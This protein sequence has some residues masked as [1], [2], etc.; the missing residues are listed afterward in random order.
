MRTWLR[1]LALTSC[2][3]PGA[4]A[5]VGVSTC[6]GDVCPCGNVD[7]LA[8]CG[9]F[10][11]DGDPLTGALLSGSGSADLF[12]DDLVL[13]AEGLAPDQFGLMAMAASGGVMIPLGD[14]NFCLSAAGGG[15]FRFPPRLSDSAGVLRETGILAAAAEF[16]AGVT[17]GSTWNFQAWYRDS[18]G[19]CGSGFNLS[20]ALA[21]TFEPPGSDRALEVELAGRPIAQF[22][23][24]ERT[25]ASNQGEDLWIN[26]D[27]G[28]LGHLSGQNVLVYVV[29]ARTSAEWDAN[30]TL[31]DVRGAAQPFLI[32]SG[33]IAAGSLLVDPGQLNGELGTQLGVGYDIVI[34][35]NMDGLL[36]PQDVID[37]RGDV[38]GVVVVRDPVQAGPFAVSSSMH[39]L[40]FFQQQVVFYPTNISSM[41]ALPLV[42]V[43]HGNGHNFQW[44]D[45]IGNHLASYGY[46]VMSHTNDTM[47]GI[48]TASLTTLENTDAFLGNLDIIANGELD[49]H[50][51]VDHMAWIGHSRGGEGIVR[52]Y[53]RV[54][55]GN[56][57]PQNFG[58]D[59][60]RLLSSIAPT[61]FLGANFSTPH[62]AN[63][64]LWVGSAD[65]D[66]T[67]SPGPGGGQS[68]PL[69]E[70]GTGP[71]A[72]TVYQGVGHGAFHNGPTGTV[73]TGPDQNSRAIT[74]DLMRGYLLPLLAFYVRGEPAG[75]DFLWR[76]W[77]N[78]GPIGRPT[79]ST[80]VVNLEYRDAPEERFVIDDF[81]S[82]PD[83]DLASS[84]AIVA[85]DLVFMEEG[86][87]QDLDLM[88][89]FSPQDTFNGMTRAN[90]VVDQPMGLVL[91]WDDPRTLE[92]QLAGGE[93]DVR[94]FDFLSFR[95]AATTRHPL[96]VLA[97]AD[98]V[99]DVTLE[100]RWGNQSS[101]RIS[102]F[103]GGV[104]EP[105]QRG[106]G[107][108]NEFEV[109]RLRVQDFISDDVN[110]DL[111]RVAIIR[112]EFARP[113]ASTE[114][115]IGIDDLEFT[116]E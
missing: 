74:H 70:R 29:E 37:G 81:Q 85:S 42:V 111:S 4:L 110:L 30:A 9:N 106:G 91:T 94:E 6:F 14:G 64:H 47:P 2:L 60:I 65:A 36:G 48:G 19:P 66:V 80:V 63:F 17:A 12:R 27:P 26:V 112:I 11:V 76:Q 82:N 1:F 57:V 33:G 40:G 87:L 13:T 75:E 41:G 22:P 24:F 77:E 114:G 116:R 104:E 7:P 61:S 55:D 18:G 25:L 93:Q 96:T 86:R 103:G 102:A 68:F 78:F 67:G 98:L 34:D 101:I 107:W 92:W 15:L 109:Q 97:L 59:D 31:I 56:F 21:V 23:F 115:A 108:S 38:P 35:V 73:A 54:F 3:S 62:D 71:K 32:G 90:G 83:M 20:N 50:V 69:Y 95:A 72:A 51:L 49:G 28:R 84:G 46:I 99:F 88:L 5:Q 53:D 45:H 8:G 113:G 44:Y 100:D 79:E 43:S 58:L 52:A 16:G 89:A 10:G 39:S 105:Y